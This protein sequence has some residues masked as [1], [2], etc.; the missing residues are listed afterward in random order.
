MNTATIEER[1]KQILQE[2]I[3]PLYKSGYRRLCVALPY[4]MQD[5]EQSF[6]KELYPHIAE[7]TGTTACSVEASIRR[8]IQAAWDHGDRA[9]WQ[10]YFPGIRKAPTNQVFIGTIAEYLK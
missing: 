9:A 7:E 5:P 10:K 1:T 8:V 2:L 6:T 4:F 3:F